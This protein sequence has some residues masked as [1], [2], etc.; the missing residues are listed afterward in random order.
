MRAS[1]YM[2]EN[3]VVPIAHDNIYWN[4][5]YS[6][7]HVGGAIESYL[8]EA[9]RRVNFPV[10]VIIP[11]SDGFMG[12][13]TTTMDRMTDRIYMKFESVRRPATFP[14]VATL[15]SRGF[16]RSNMLYLPLDDE[17]FRVGLEQVLS[18]VP[19]PAWEDRKPVAFWRG[20]V[21]GYDRPTLRELV[22]RALYDVP[23]T[24]VRLTAWGGWERGHNIPSHLFADRC[25]IAEHLQNKYL[26]IV[27]GNC[28]ASNHQWVF[29]SGS[30]PVMITH[31]ENRYWFD[32][33]L[34]PMVNYVPIKHDL[35]DLKEKIAWLQE[36]DAEAKHIAENAVALSKEIFSPEFQR[37]YIDRALF[38]IINGTASALFLRHKE[39]VTKPT[40][41]NEHLET[42]YT[43]A[44]KCN[45]VVECGV[46]DV[47][48]SYSFAAG[49]VGTPNNAYTM[50][51][52]Y[53]SRNV[54]PFISLCRQEGVNV[55]FINSDDTTCDPI[56]T[57][58]LFIDTWHVYAHLKCELAHWHAH[59][60]KY[61]LMHD[62]TVDEVHGESIRAGYDT[63]AQS[64][65]SGYPEEEI[66]KGLGP[67]I[68]E[69]LEAHPEWTIEQ[70]YT[71][72]NGLT[73]LARK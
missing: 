54:E 21:S 72:N 6:Q 50:I 32:S 20:A 60:R 71:H 57:D 10:T 39:N 38:T 47:V 33:Y 35:S 18:D 2:T 59:V 67:A 43:Y 40:D 70:K 58:M 64:R 42:L 11:K 55:R 61:I 44:K 8:R 45:S 63:A 49:L 15:C 13:W 37:R 30:V 22:T 1:V 14:I 68:A 3:T 23:G 19:K 12:P 36:H 53:V 29:G 34:K 26:L 52:T 66:R 9:V 51:D 4:G 41:I 48:S 69:F 17:T 56:E 62:T 46:R 5:G 24:D 27:D 28:I 7:F 25:G 65:E 31:P 73:I 16:D